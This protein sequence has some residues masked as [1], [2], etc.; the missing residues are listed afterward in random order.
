MDG[1]T[2]MELGIY[3]AHLGVTKMLLRSMGMCLLVLLTP[4]AVA[5][6]EAKTAEP[7]T[8]EHTVAG[9]SESAD[10]AEGDLRESDETGRQGDEEHG[11]NHDERGGH[12]ANLTDVINDEIEKQRST[13]GCASIN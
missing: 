9:S 12:H 13:A 1:H 7:K 6:Q 8:T 3:T 4:L 5:A 2:P 10:G 11:G